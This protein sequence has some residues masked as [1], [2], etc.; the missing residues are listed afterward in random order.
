MHN[1]GMQLSVP[2]IRLLLPHYTIEADYEN[3]IWDDGD[4]TDW[5]GSNVAVL[6]GNLDP[7]TRLYD[8]KA[9]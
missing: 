9:R 4:P 1:R 7:A 5:I 8:V 6:G 3:I 2:S